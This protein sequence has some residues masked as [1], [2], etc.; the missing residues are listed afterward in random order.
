[1]TIGKNDEGSNLI[2]VQQNYQNEKKAKIDDWRLKQMGKSGLINKNPIMTIFAAQKAIAKK[3][4]IGG[5]PKNGVISKPKRKIK[6]LDSQIGCDFRIDPDEYEN[7]LSESCYD[8][9]RD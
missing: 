2:R 7:A 5:G 1:M 6:R 3:T 4:L 8:A 9:L